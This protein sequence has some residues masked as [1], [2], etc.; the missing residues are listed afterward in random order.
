MNRAQVRV[1]G[2]FMILL[3]LVTNLGRCSVAYAIEEEDVR[4]ELRLS[5][6]AVAEAERMGGDVSDLVSE[7]N[8]IAERLEIAEKEDYFNLIS[9]LREVGARAWLLGG[10]GQTVGVDQF[11]LS[12]EILVFTGL[13]VFLVWAFFPVLFWRSWLRFKGDWVVSS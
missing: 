6:E 7:L 4:A 8:L 10:V 3:V 5:F 2:F 1:P 9:R 13:L 12:V 11:N